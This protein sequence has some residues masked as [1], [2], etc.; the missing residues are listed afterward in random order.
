MFLHNWHSILS[1][2][3]NVAQVSLTRLHIRS[4]LL[5]TCL[6]KSSVLCR[7]QTAIQHAIVLKCKKRKWSIIFKW[8]LYGGWL[9]SYQRK[10]SIVFLVKTVLWGSTSSS[11]KIKP[12][13]SSQRCRFWIARLSLMSL[14]QP[15]SELID[16]PRPMKSTNV[17]PSR[18]NN[19]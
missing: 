14:L 10:F 13:D 19:R 1:N 9:K 18:L 16:N 12:D 2:F 4:L 17:K 5:I 3:R 15:T 11:R 7:F 8:R 6:L